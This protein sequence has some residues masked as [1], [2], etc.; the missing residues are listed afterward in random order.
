MG[1]SRVK[2]VYTN[3]SGKDILGDEFAV[4]TYDILKS[5]SH[6]TLGRSNPPNY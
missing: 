5:T 6:P 3:S 2:H 4:Y 1:H